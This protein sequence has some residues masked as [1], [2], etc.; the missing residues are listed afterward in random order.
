M[1]M[2]YNVTKVP[3][4]W[5]LLK[6]YLIFKLFIR[7]RGGELRNEWCLFQKEPSCRGKNSGVGVARMYSRKKREVGGNRRTKFKIAEIHPIW[8]RKTRGTA[9]RTIIISNLH[10]LRWHTQLDVIKIFLLHVL[11]QKLSI[12]L[13]LINSDSSQFASRRFLIRQAR[14]LYNLK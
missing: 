13:S 4:K 5:C 1:F 2:R 6:I 12:Q 10:V 8:A 14:L 11:A 7:K 3:H 9:I